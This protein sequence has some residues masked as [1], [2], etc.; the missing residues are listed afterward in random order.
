MVVVRRM[1]GRTGVGVCR[2][3]RRHGPASCAK[4]PHPVNPGL[5]RA[6]VRNHARRLFLDVFLERALT[7]REWLLAEADLARKME[8]AGL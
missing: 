4:Q 8:T 2:D 1:G 3:I 5:T 7:Q 6:M